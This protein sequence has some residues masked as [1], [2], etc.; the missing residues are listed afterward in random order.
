MDRTANFQSTQNDT[1][2]FQVCDIVF[3]K[4]AI[5]CKNRRFWQVS[6]GYPHGFPPPAETI[7]HDES[8]FRR[9]ISSNSAGILGVP[10]GRAPGLWGVLDE[11]NT[12]QFRVHF[13]RFD[14]VIREPK[15]VDL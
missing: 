2:W 10:S 1:D 12:V 6:T 3:A 5:V 8:Q 14:D 7:G 13:K 9:A 4:I 11:Q 15:R